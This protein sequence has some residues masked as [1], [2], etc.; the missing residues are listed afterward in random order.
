MVGAVSCS[1]HYIRLT[2]PQL[3]PTLP[4]GQRHVSGRHVSP[5]LLGCLL[6]LGHVGV[7]RVQH[8]L[9]LRGLV[10]AVQHLRGGAV[11]SAVHRRGC[12]YVL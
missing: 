7:D 8:G 4:P 10:H 1:S 2:G 3:P 5:R 12:W 11:Q 9:E 6:L